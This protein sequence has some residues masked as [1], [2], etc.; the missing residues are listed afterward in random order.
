MQETPASPMEMT[1][2]PL[3][4]EITLP[5]M[6]ETVSIT[7]IIEYSYD[8]TTQGPVLVVA[9]KSPKSPPFDI[10]WPI[11]DGYTV[12]IAVYGLAELPGGVP[13]GSYGL[14]IPQNAGAVYIIAVHDSNG[15]FVHDAGEPWGE[16]P[17]NPLNVG[18]QDIPNV[19][20]PLAA[21]QSR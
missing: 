13:D 6:Q 5:G 4:E 14:Q 9:F 17:G 15:N 8:Y 2:A 11:E 16:Y 10:L 20:F 7:G 19:N 1:P 3:E 18:T 21:Q 12:Q